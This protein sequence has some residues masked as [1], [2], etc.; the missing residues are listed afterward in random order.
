MGTA[1][2]GLTVPRSVVLVAVVVALLL[3]VVF[4]L[5][6][7]LV[8]F[9]AGRPPPVADVLPGGSEVTFTTADG[10]ALSAWY[11]PGGPVG[12]VVLPG[13]A[14]NRAGRVPLATALAELGLSVVLVDY[15]GY[16]GNPGT[17][18]QVGLERDGEAAATW[19]AARPGLRHVVYFGESIGAAVAIAVAVR[20]PPAALILRS[21]FTSLADVARVHYGPVPDWLLRDRF[22]SAERVA[23][24]EAPVLVIAGED[25]RIVPIAQSRRL[26]AAAN[27]PKHFVAIPSAGHNDLALLHGERMMAEIA[28]F[29]SVHGL[30]G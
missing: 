1:D 19:L 25:D 20:H 9:P 26:F 21:P 6:R 17:P 11:L 23:S 2:T 27:E 3:L 30:P 29:L 10:V 24:V 4:A 13:N 28:T 15:R 16:G 12:V 7:R 18:T 8:Y 14:G 22:P 5:Q